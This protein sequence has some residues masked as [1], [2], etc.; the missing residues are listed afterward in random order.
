[1]WVRELEQFMLVKVSYE[2]KASGNVT[3]KVAEPG[4]QMEKMLGTS[5]T[6]VHR[7]MDEASPQWLWVLQ[8][9]TIVWECLVG[10][11]LHRQGVGR[12]W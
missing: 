10:G 6:Q 8:R 11:D 7:Y 12:C 3:W 4:E 9:S 5:D 2:A 1:M